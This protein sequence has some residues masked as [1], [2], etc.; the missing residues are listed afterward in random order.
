MDRPSVKADAVSDPTRSPAAN[1]RFQSGAE[2]RPAKLP[3][4]AA[5][6]LRNHPCYG[7]DARH[8]F[9]RIHLAVAPACNIQCHYCNRRYDC[10][11]E[12]RPGVTSQVL[13]PA[14]ALEHTLNTAAQLPNLSVV[15]IAGPGDPLANPDATFR[16][17][18]LVRGALPDLTLC[19]STNGLALPDHVDALAELG[20]NH[21]TV[22]VNAV[23][24]AVG[25]RIH[26]WVYRDGKRWHGEE[27]SAL[28]QDRQLE[29]IRRAIAKGMLVK[30][31]TVLVPGVNDAHVAEVSRRTRELGVFLHNVMPLLVA[32]EYETHY[33]KTGQR[34]PTDAELEAARSSCGESRMMRH[35]RGCRADAVGMLG[36]AT[37]LAPPAPAAVG[38]DPAPREAHRAY[39]AEQRARTTAARDHALARLAL[40]SG[41]APARVAVATRG[42]GMV[43]EHF[44]RASELEV[45]EVDATG[46]RL[47][48]IR[49][50]AT[51][52]AGGYEDEEAL[53][54]VLVALQ[55]CAAVLVTRVGPCPRD[56]LAREG[57]EA[58]TR[59][60]FQPIE[61]ALLEWFCG[62][63]GAPELAVEGAPALPVE[64][65]PELP[66][67]KVA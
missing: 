43:N 41:A 16:T 24:P 9:A 37:P 63:V 10:A 51:S 38:R 52:C 30:I 28:L 56:G 12:N 57:I 1:C 27:A 11:A 6:K 50:V 66:I 61:V 23:D 59:H 55:G 47:L 67:V 46:A 64:G 7:E 49:K 19:I 20:V 22:T 31:N 21:V 2:E 60:A 3:P 62:H 25:A 26:P 45:Y 29:G 17:L 14:Q 13:S 44:G 35:C 65:T 8:H 36:K 5:E 54:E 53:D 42:N 48:G 39:V 15:G 33:S 58:V 40:V 18:E 32:P 34:G 4:G